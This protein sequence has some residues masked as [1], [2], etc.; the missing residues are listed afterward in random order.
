MFPPEKSAG[1]FTSIQGG[2]IKFRRPLMPATAT[3][4][5]K[6]NKSQSFHDISP[7]GVSSQNRKT[8]SSASRH[9][10]TP[11]LSSNFLICPSCSA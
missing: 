4:E 8:F 3:S 11:Y 7:L 1:R 5:K 10:F 2:L 9:T 6:N